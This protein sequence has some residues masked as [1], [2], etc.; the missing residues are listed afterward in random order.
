MDII[1][2]RAFEYWKKEMGDEKHRLHC[3]LVIK[4][5]LGMIENT[6]L[7]EEVF[8]ISGWIHDM[9]KLISKKNHNEESLKF[10]NIFLE[11]NTEFEKY[12]NE[13]EDCVLNHR[14]GLIPKTVYGQIFQLSDKVALRNLDWIKYKKKA[15]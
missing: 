9:G 7:N 4:S 6:D 15:I 12:R 14:T 13:I 5:C 10:L 2:N 8:I 3:S 1:N 11:E